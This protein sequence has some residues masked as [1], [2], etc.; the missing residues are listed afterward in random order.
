MRELQD[1]FWPLRP[2][3]FP[4]D[5]PSHR[6][7][8]EVFY[9]HPAVPMIMEALLSEKSAKRKRAQGK[10]RRIWLSA[11]DLRIR[12]LSGIA[13]HIKSIA[14]ELWE[15]APDR[16]Q[17]WQEWQT[18]IADPILAVIDRYLRDSAE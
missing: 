13:A 15:A 8:R 16:A 7:G 17:E 1:L 9:D 12:V 4:K 2:D 3:R 14:S 5:L 10:A 6:D 11:P 18:E